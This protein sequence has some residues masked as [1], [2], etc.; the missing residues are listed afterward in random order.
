MEA[1]LGVGVGRFGEIWARVGKG[2]Q[3]WTGQTAR[4]EMGD[5]ASGWV[6]VC[7]QV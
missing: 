4:A 5:M 6:W 3:V 1:G 2:G 7:L